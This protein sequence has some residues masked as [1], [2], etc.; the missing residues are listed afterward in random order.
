[1]PVKAQYVGRVGVL[2]VALGLGAAVANT[3]G[4]AFAEPTDSSSSSSSSDS[5][6]STSSSSSE[7]AQ[8]VITIRRRQQIRRPQQPAPRQVRRLGMCRVR[9]TPK[10]VRPPH[11][12]TLRRQTHA[13][14]LCR[15]RAARTPAR[16]RR[17]ATP[18]HR[19]RR[20]PTQTGVPAAVATT[21]PAEPSTAALPTQQAGAASP[22]S[23]RPRRHPPRSRC[24]R[25]YAGGGNIGNPSRYR[26][27]AATGCAAR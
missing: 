11:Q 21:A 22:T 7:S 19:P 3:P 17:A 8:A 23:N 12:L 25:R 13:L 18:P 15:V 24:H 2:A 26:G 14:G 1:M 20:R 9:L 5:S 6:S 27:R 10:P 4:V 16:H